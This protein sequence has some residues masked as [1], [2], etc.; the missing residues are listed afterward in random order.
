MHMSFRSLIGSPVS[1]STLIRVTGYKDGAI[2]VVKPTDPT[3]LSTL[4]EM[5]N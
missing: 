4:T 5:S 2:L 1:L 3:V